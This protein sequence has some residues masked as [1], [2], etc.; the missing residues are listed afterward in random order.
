MGV[1]PD[2]D[3]ASPELI[4][5]ALAVRAGGELTFTVEERQRTRDTVTAIT[6]DYDQLKLTL[7]IRVETTATETKEITP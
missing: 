4:I 3:V 2:E 5:A 6:A 7:T 1:I